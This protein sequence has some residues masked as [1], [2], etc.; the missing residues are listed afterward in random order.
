[1]SKFDWSEE[2]LKYCNV[3]VEAATNLSEAEFADIRRNGIGASDA[4]VILGT[5]PWAKLE[6]ITEDKLAKGYTAKNAEISTKPNVRKGSDLEPLILKKAEE[7]IARPVIKPTAM[8]RFKNYPWLTV[9]YDGITNIFDQ[10][11]PVEAKMVSTFGEKGWNWGKSWAKGEMQKAFSTRPNIGI[12]ERCKQAGEHYG[13]PPYYYCQ[14]QQ[15]MAGIGASFG[16]M[17]AL[18]DKDWTLRLYMVH[19]DNLLL[20]EL[21]DKSRTFWNTI[22]VKKGGQV[23]ATVGID[24]GTSGEENTRSIASSN[25]PDAEEY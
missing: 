24:S 11:V 3:D 16:F 22:A 7:A 25:R 19:R 18:H 12:E 2:I 4:S 15:Q 9:N 17:A 1:M 8:Y 13:I 10:W 23:Y 14:L 6:D 5:N 20:Q 21:V